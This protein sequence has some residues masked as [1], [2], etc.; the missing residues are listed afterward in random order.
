MMFNFD[1]KKIEKEME[2]ECVKE[3]VIEHIKNKIY[4]ELDP[5]WN[6][7]KAEDGSYYY[8]NNFTGDRT[9][10]GKERCKEISIEKEFLERISA[11]IAEKLYNNYKGW[12]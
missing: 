4:A 7:Y 3:K 10:I 12:Q 2:Q 9:D 1:I 8:F 5:N 11:K 6:I